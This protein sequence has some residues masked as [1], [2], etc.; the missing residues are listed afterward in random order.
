MTAPPKRR[1]VRRPHLDAA[2]VPVERALT[3]IAEVLKQQSPAIGEEAYPLLT[4]Q[5]GNE[6][7]LLVAAVLGMIVEE[8]HWVP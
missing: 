7:N 6:V 4:A 8:L 1:T 2:S 3:A 5:C